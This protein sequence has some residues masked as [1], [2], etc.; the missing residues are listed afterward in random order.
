[1]EKLN[2]AKHWTS[3][4]VE[5]FTYRIA[6]DFIAQVELHIED[7]GPTKTELA[8][9]LQRTVGRVSQMFNPGNTTVS[10]AVRLC[11]AC[12]MKVALVAYEDDDPNNDAGPINSEIFRRCWEH[13]GSPT[14]FFEL[15]HAIA[16]IKHFGYFDQAAN[17]VDSDMSALRLSQNAITLPN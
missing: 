4:S 16:P 1:M 7:N 2:A 3:R 8:E 13:M 11:G 9:R 14:N 12:G 17:G 6:S 15:E 5:D 10:S